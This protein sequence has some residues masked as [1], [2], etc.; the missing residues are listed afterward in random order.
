MLFNTGPGRQDET[1]KDEDISVPD[2][3]VGGTPRNTERFFASG[4]ERTVVNFQKMGFEKIGYKIN[5]ADRFGIIMELMN[6]N[7]ADKR[8]FFTVTYNIVEDHP[9]AESVKPVWFDARNCGTSHVNPPPKKGSFAQCQ[10][11]LL[12]E[13]RS[14]QRSMD[15]DSDRFQGRPSHGNMGQVAARLMCSV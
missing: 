6:M 11:A 14:L 9:Y 5:T 8:V 10:E 2:A 3:V 15:L 4:N 1:C 12:T 13:C 7:P